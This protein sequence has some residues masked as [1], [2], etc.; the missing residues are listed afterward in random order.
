MSLVTRCPACRTAFR[1][2]R[3]QLATHSGS[4][5]CGKC[6]EVFNGITGL[7]EEGAEQSSIDPSPQPGL[8]DP[9]R[10]P[11][12]AARPPEHQGALP[13]FMAGTERAPGRAWLWAGAAVAAAALLTAQVAYHYRAEI[14]AFLPEARAP[15]LA[16]CQQL[17]CAV[18][19][20][21]RPDVLSIEASDL[22]ADPRRQGVIVLHA[23]I[24]NRSRL[25]QQYPALE[26]TLTDE[27]GRP[28]LRRVL[29]PRDYVEPEQARDGIAAGGEAALRVYL[30]SGGERVTS[31]RLY[32]FYPA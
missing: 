19:L 5:R 1:V 32:L 21:R 10:R 20:P 22:Q 15:L 9:S 31:Y 7:V 8:F 24:R 2:R 23:L 16:A 30:D 26:L 25:P 29:L 17:G 14:A 28:V 13:R 12:P 18:A 27:G 3:E 6:A 11:L 4:V